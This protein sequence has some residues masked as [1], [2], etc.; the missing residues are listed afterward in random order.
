MVFCFM[1]SLLK[2]NFIGREII[3]GAMIS[4]YQKSKCKSSLLRTLFFVLHPVLMK[5]GLSTLGRKT[6]RPARGGSF[7]FIRGAGE[8]RTLVQIRNK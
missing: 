3:A 6:K 7:A 1:P 2:V 8:I 4:P 5:A